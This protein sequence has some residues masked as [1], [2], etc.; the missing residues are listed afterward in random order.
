MFSASDA[1]EVLGLSSFQGQLQSKVKASYHRLALLYHPD[2][3]VDPNATGKFQEIN[4]AYEQLMKTAKDDTNDRY[5][6]S[7]NVWFEHILPLLQ[8]MGYDTQPSVTRVT[9]F[10]VH[11]Y[12]TALLPRLDTMNKEK[13]EKMYQFIC[14]HRR[15]FPAVVDP[16]V[17]YI[18][19]LINSTAHKSNYKDQHMMLYPTLEELLGGK[20]LQYKKGGRTYH[21]PSWNSE[22]VFDWEPDIDLKEN[23]KEGGEFIVHCVPVCPEGV[24]VDDNQCIHKDVVYTMSELWEV[25]DKVSCKVELAPTITLSFDIS[26]LK[27]VRTPQVVGFYCKGIPL[28]SSMDVLDASNKG[29]VELHVTIK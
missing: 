11:V 24:T 7:A 5:P 4:E 9:R 26:S 23:T 21:I 12:D 17:N 16:L 2:K 1:R 19:K 13:L 14:K 6:Y 18:G 22:T 27:L 3:S 28:I 15:R 8:Q 10:L 25:P 29:K 20:I